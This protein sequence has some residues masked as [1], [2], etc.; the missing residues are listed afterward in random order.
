MDPPRDLV[1]E[2]SGSEDAVGEAEAGGQN[3]DVGGV[4]EEVGVDQGRVRGGGRSD[5]HGAAGERVHVA[6]DE[7]VAGVVGG[8][9]AGHELGAVG[10]TRGG[11]E[12]GGRADDLDVCGGK[13]GGGGGGGREGGG[14]GEGGAPHAGGDGFVLEFLEG[15]VLGGR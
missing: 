10:E 3:V 4:G 12:V 8:G 9:G 6:D 15:G 14:G 13:G 1:G 7:R 5:V 2:R 11:V